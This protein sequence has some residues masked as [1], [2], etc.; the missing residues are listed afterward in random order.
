MKIDNEFTVSVPLD[1]AWEVLTDLQEVA[2]CLP[3]A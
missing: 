3:G 2:L 1:Q